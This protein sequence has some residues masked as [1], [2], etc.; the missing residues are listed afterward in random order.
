M[1]AIQN[2]SQLM[3][4]RLSFL[5]TMQTAKILPSSDKQPYL[6]GLKIENLPAAG[7]SQSIIT[8]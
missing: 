1:V 2:R 3:W 7:L 4:D 5:A 8:D 6:T